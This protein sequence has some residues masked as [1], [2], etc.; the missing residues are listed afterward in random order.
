MTT[1]TKLLDIQQLFIDTERFVL[2][3][4][5]Q[6]SVLDL[7]VVGYPSCWQA[8]LDPSALRTS[9][10]LTD[11]D[12]KDPQET[13]LELLKSSETR[14]LELVRHDGDTT[15]GLYVKERLPSGLV[16]NRWTHTLESISSTSGWMDLLDDFVEY[17]QH[18]VQQVDH[19]KDARRNITTSRDEWKETARQLEG[20]WELE[21]TRLLQNFA[22]LY[23]DMKSH[24]KTTIKN[25]KKEI[26]QLQAQNAQLAERA[27][28][29]AKRTLPAPVPLPEDPVGLDEETIDRLAKGERVPVAEEPPRA[30]KRKTVPK[31]K[32]PPPR[33]KPVPKKKESD[34]EEENDFQDDS[35]DVEPTPN[36]P[37]PKAQQEPKAPASPP[38]VEE[39]RSPPEPKA[40]AFDFDSDDSDFDLTKLQPKRQKPTSTP[41]PA[42]SKPTPKPT[43]ASSDE[44]EPAPRKRAPARKDKTTKKKPAKMPAKKPTKRAAKPSSP[45]DSDSD[46]EDSDMDDMLMAKIKAMRK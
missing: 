45:D 38:P 17:H 2:I 13:F 7:R 43:A 24:Y 39:T 36:I 1:T 5:D 32:A 4:S 19:L 16:K 41:E 25:D 26:E 37:S 33:P 28:R 29:A 11:D 34:D 40:P 27:A 44:E 31:A 8:A 10:K 15:V 14:K 6:D 18:R 42:R 35:M 46:L 22:K 9:L 12:D 3:V 21:K 20:G 23:E 30:K